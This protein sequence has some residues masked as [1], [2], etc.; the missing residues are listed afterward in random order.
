MKKEIKN[1]LSI[2]SRII[3]HLPLKTSHN[4]IDTIDPSRKARVSRRDCQLDVRVCFNE[5]IQART[6]HMELHISLKF[7]N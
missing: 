3:V 7:L 1:T 4:L 5:F 2:E 6:G